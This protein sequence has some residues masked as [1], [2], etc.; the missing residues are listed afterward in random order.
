MAQLSTDRIGEMVLLLTRVAKIKKTPDV[1]A[2]ADK[3]LSEEKLIYKI[4]NKIRGEANG[5][6]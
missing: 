6:K 1:V 2:L 4:Q 3:L 5:Y